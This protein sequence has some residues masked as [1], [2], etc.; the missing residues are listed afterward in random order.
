MKAAIQCNFC[1]SCCSTNVTV[2]GVPRL[3]AGWKRHE[4]C[5]YC[6]KC[7]RDRFVLRAVTFPV[8]GPIPHDWDRL[9]EA[10][11]RAWKQS[12]ELANWTLTALAKADVVRTADMKKLP[13]MPH[14]YLYPEA[15]NR[16]PTMASRRLAAVLRSVEQRYRQKRFEVVWRCESALSSYRY[17]FPYPVHNQAWKAHYGENGQVLVDVPLDGD[18]YTLVLRRGDHFRRQIAAFNMIVQGKGI[19]GELQLYRQRASSSDHRSGIEAREAGGGG[20]VQ[21]RVMAKLTAWLPK[22]QTAR[23][24]E[25]ILMV[26]TVPDAFCV[27]EIAGQDAPW[28]FNGDH[29]KRWVAE[30]RARLHRLHEDVQN[31]RHTST[32]CCEHG[33][34]AFV[35]KHRQRITTW[36]HQVTSA[37]AQIADR[38]NVAAVKYDDSDRRF[39]GDFPWSEVSRLLAIKLGERGIQVVFVRDNISRD[40]ADNST[41]KAA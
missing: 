6:K 30:H 41:K 34:D 29:V 3:P 21:Y 36:C 2:R 16:V 31:T 25:G 37:L 24:R 8:V 22:V 32:I 26:R 20:R 1:S 39:L 27:A 14:V 13:A 15:R 18:K 19:Q 23:A 10:L 4:D 12:T 9:R 28:H 17:P 40:V 5:V 11:T 33:R 35:A 7:W 38:Q